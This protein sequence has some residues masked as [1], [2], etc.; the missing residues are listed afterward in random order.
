MD[1]GASSLYPP[2]TQGLFLG[3]P[4]SFFP[5]TTDAAPSL[6]GNLSSLQTPRLS[7]CRW[8]HSQYWKTMS[9]RSTALQRPTQLSPSTGKRRCGGGRAGPLGPPHPC[10]LRELS[11]VVLGTSHHAWFPA[12]TQYPSPF[13]A[14]P[15]Y[16]SQV[17]APFLPP[18]PL[19]PSQ[20]EFLS[21][22]HTYT[23]FHWR[24]YLFCLNSL[25]IP[26]F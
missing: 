3:L 7:T 18:S 17:R 15:I 4:A 2:C 1:C 23:P 20:V 13:P 8:N 6:Q 11:L 19:P 26:Y 5:K 25:L 16:P 10:P 14:T 9:S 24:R 21:L 12:G 22:T